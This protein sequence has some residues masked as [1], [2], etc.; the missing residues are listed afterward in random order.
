MPAN[1]EDVRSKAKVKTNLWPLAPMRQPG[2][3]LYTDLTEDTFSD[4]L[5]ELVSEDNFLMDALPGV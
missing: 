2:R 1:S 3:H 5:D 4:F